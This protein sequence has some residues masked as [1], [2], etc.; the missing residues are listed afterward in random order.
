MQDYWTSA[1]LCSRCLVVFLCS[2][3]SGS[4]LAFFHLCLVSILFSA[5]SILKW[6]EVSEKPFSLVSVPFRGFSTPPFNRWHKHM[7]YCRRKKERKKNAFCA[8]AQ[9]TFFFLFYSDECYNAGDKRVESVHSN[10]H[11]HNYTCSYQQFS[12]RSSL[13]IATHRHSPSKTGGS[14]TLVL[15]QRVRYTHKLYTQ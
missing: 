6:N 12:S 11:P 4:L 15:T 5:P 3:L 1:K 7:L 2:F 9:N 8:I 13:A 14:Q 10:F